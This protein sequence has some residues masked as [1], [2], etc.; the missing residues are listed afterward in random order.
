MNN[1]GYTGLSFPLK[2]SSK[3]GL[4][5][6][7]TSPTDFTHIEESIKQILATS[8][9]ERVS[10]LYFGSSI[11]THVF[12]VSDEASYSLIKH[13][14]VE[15]LNSFEKRI[16]VSTEGIDLSN[17]LDEIT[18][19]NFLNITVHYKVIKYDRTSSVDVV[20]GED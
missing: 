14:I 2:I 10:E 19:K 13:E 5:M 7:T 8:V 12:E 16:E 20:L 6:T 11:S 4:K 3:G 15:A 18:G 9:G 17:T 1:T